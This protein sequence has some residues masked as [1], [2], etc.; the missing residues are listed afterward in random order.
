MIE[1]MVEVYM[2]MTEGL[3]NR[4]D[5]MPCWIGTPIMVLLALPLLFGYVVLDMIDHNNRKRERDAI[6][7]G[8]IEVKRVEHK[9][10]PTFREIFLDVY[11]ERQRAGQV[12]VGSDAEVVSFLRANDETRH[13]RLWKMLEHSC[14]RRYERKTGKRIG[15]TATWDDFRTWL[16]DNWPDIIRVLCSV[17]MLFLML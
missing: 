4:L 1:R 3:F 9:S 10:N 12:D 14:V 2:G 11:E 16:K 5:R 7:D 13:P 15:S 17:L 6:L 8:M